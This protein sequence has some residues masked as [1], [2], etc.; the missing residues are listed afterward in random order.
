MLQA[1]GIGEGDGEGSG[2]GEGELAGEGEGWGVAVGVGVGT[3]VGEGD[4]DGMGVGEG[5]GLGEGSGVGDGPGVGVGVGVGMGGGVGLAEEEMWIAARAWSTLTTKSLT[6]VTV[7]GRA[8]NF[9]GF[10]SLIWA[11]IDLIKGGSLTLPES[12]A[13]S[14]LTYL[15]LVARLLKVMGLLTASFAA[16]R[17]RLVSLPSPLVR[18]VVGIAELVAAP[19]ENASELFSML[20]L[21]R[22]FSSSMTGILG[23]PVPTL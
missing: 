18:S 11:S 8:V 13:E 2:V 6:S 1:T 15:V 20:S 10:S 5:D 7:F 12:V 4:G 21:P 9:A 16:K 3:G 22:K 23:V 19:E 14:K 17:S